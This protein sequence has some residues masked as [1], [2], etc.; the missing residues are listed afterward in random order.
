MQESAYLPLAF[1][2]IC[3]DGLCFRRNTYISA[4]MSGVSQ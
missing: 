2:Q 4:I 1:V 3:Q